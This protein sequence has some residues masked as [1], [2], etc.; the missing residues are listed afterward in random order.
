MKNIK[1]KSLLKE[2][3]DYVD[4]FNNNKFRLS[5]TFVD[6]HRKRYGEN[7]KYDDPK[8]WT[9]KLAKIYKVKPGDTSIQ[10]SWMAK[11]AQFN[12][13]SPRWSIMIPFKDVFKHKLLDKI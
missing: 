1:L 3:V 5:K 7:V 10:I 8:K 4:Y 6:W 13:Y 11:Y 9:G 2:E 12:D